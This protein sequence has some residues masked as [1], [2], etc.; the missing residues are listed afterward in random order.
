[1]APPVQLGGQAGGALEP[2]QSVIQITQ[3]LWRLYIPWS[4]LT[5]VGDAWLRIEYEGDLARLYSGSLLLDDH[6]YNGETWVV[7]LKRLA[8]SVK[9][10]V[11]TLAIMPLRSDAPVYIQHKPTFDLNGQAC[12]VRN[13]TISVIYS[14][15][16]V[17]S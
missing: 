15:E 3:G 6:F 8:S 16:V 17:V 1:M 11:L 13:V 10:G 14:L 12:A 5:N 2:N 9:D 4:E 7:S